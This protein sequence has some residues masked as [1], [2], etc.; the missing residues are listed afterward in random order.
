M[1][2]LLLSP[3]MLPSSMDRRMLVD[4]RMLSSLCVANDDQATMMTVPLQ[5]QT[6]ADGLA[7]QIQ[8][9]S[10]GRFLDSATTRL[11]T[12]LVSFNANQRVFGVTVFECTQLVAGRFEQ[13]ISVTAVNAAWPTHTWQ[14][15]SNLALPFAACVL[16]LWSGGWFVATAHVP[17]DDQS[18]RSC[19]T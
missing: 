19:V 11:E 5:T 13:D 18:V 17:E 3:F 14:G 16:V 8:F 4:M 2:D 9:L 10:E 15:I 1:R 7:R 6:N 12:V